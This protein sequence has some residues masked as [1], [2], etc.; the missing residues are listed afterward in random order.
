MRV[1]ANDWSRSN[2]LTVLCGLSLFAGTIAC[3]NFES[4]ASDD[5][6]LSVEVLSSPLEFPEQSE[7][8]ILADRILAD[9]S[10]ALLFDTERRNNLISEIEQVLKLVRETH[11]A[12]AEISAIENHQ[13]ETL[14]VG[15]TSE[16]MKS[17]SEIVS[18]ENR[19]ITLHT[20]NEEFD[21]LNSRLGVHA[22]ESYT[23]F[24]NV[25]LHF[26]FPVNLLQAQFEYSMIAGV[27][28]AELNSRVGDY[29][30]IEMVKFNNE[31][32][33]MF[34]KAWGDCPSGCLYE[35]LMFFRVRGGKVKRIKEQAFMDSIK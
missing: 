10:D 29:S 27:E 32:F 2:F 17:V 34:R 20:G 18:G 9:Q 7:S 31:W 16:L 4:V 19:Y 21:A 33:V 24:N 12:T 30:D 22:I 14:I 35:E 15:L 23:L 11:P 8:T 28:Y 6:R 25:I 13:P 26:K 1:I 5:T 3:T